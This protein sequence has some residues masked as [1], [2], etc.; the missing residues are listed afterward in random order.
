MSKES[1][2]SFITIS[3]LDTKADKK[4]A[5]E[6]AAGESITVKFNDLDS[7]VLRALADRIMT[8]KDDIEEAKHDLEQSQPSHIDD[9]KDQA[10]HLMQSAELTGQAVQLE[11]FA[12]Y[13]AKLMTTFDIII[14]QTQESIDRHNELQRKLEENSK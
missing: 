11:K 6:P 12:S 9:P 14:P 8:E 4:T 2:N 13:I 3:S 1:F 7:F 5:S 10:R